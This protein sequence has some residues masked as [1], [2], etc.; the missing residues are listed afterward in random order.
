MLTNAEPLRSSPSSVP[1]S[2]EPG[3]HPHAGRRNGVAIASPSSLVFPEPGGRIGSTPMCKLLDEECRA[4]IEARIASASSLV[5]YVGVDGTLAPVVTDPEP[6]GLPGDT[7]AILEDLSTRSGVLVAL[8]SGRP[9]AELR[10]RVSIPSVVYG[11]DHGLE[12][13]G[14]SLRFEHPE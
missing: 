1:R 12:I 4:E 13:E 11:G 2:P 6:A 8:L 9:L 10:S 5:V 3:L 7:Q 14:P